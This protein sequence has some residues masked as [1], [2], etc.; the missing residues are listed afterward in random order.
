[1]TKFVDSVDLAARSLGGAVIA[2]S[3]EWFAEKENLLKPQP[4]AHDPDAFGPKG[5]AYDGWETR[6]RRGPGHDWAIIRLGTPGIVRS[7]VVDTT[8]FRGNSPEEV[9]VEATGLDGT[10]DM[11]TLLA[12]G[13]AWETLVPRAPVRGDAQN[14]FEVDR[15]R[16]FTHLRLRMYPDGGIAR[17]RTYGDVIPDPR[18]LAGAPVDLLAQENGGLAIDCSDRFFSSPHNLNAPGL[19]RHM[20]EGWENRRRRGPGNDWVLFRLAAPGLATRAEIDTTFF[21]GNAPEEAALRGCDATG[22]SLDDRDAWF[23][24]VPRQKLVPDTRHRYLV[25]GAARATHVRLDVYPDGGVARVRLYGD[26]DAR[27]RSAL[28]VRWFDLLPAAQALAVLAGCGVSR[29]WSRVVA[30]ARP[31]RDIAGVDAALATASRQHREAGQSR[32]RALLAG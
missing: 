2:A 25:E 14:R 26:L 21:L 11:A 18:Y 16:R 31:L 12:E 13:V 6:R 23:D 4:P 30:E 24:I 3:D 9:S 27:T 20:G 29:H 7:V 19:P 1:M 5:K 22:A 32:V 10:P 15:E 28:A 17:F 8:F